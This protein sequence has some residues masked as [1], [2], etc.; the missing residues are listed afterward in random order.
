M[1]DFKHEP[2][3]RIREDVAGEGI[4]VRLW[5]ELMQQVPE[6]S[7]YTIYEP[8]TKLGEL[9]MFCPVQVSQRTASIC[10]EFCRYLGTNGGR[11]YLH[12]LSEQI[13]LQGSSSR[14]ALAAW[15]IENERRHGI[16]GGARTV[17]FMLST[18]W[19]ETAKWEEVSR[20]DIE[21]IEVM[22][23][24]L[25][26]KEGRDFVATG[27]QEIEDATRQRRTDQLEAF[28]SANHRIQP[29]SAIALLR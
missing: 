16:N 14:G 13:E 15:A 11:G 27:L 3:K 18:V 17:D 21:T 9:M 10:A 26:S 1:S 24:W 23:E 22:A 4:F 5:Q 7:H 29:I 28:W 20:D 19:G 25:G 6:E 8:N 12:V 2:L